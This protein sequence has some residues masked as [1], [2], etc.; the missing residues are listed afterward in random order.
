MNQAHLVCW[1]WGPSMVCTCICLGLHDPDAVHGV[2]VEDAPRKDSPFPIG[3][4]HS[5][6][7]LR[8]GA[9]HHAVHCPTEH[10]GAAAPSE[11]A[12]LAALEVHPRHTCPNA[13]TRKTQRTRG[14]EGG[15]RAGAQ[16]RPWHSA[17]RDRG[18]STP[19]GDPSEP[20]AAPKQDPGKP[21]ARG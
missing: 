4:G 3:K 2:G 16:P 11:E 1:E 12:G 8:R 14:G 20:L 18:L 6:P 17:P 13:E 9:P 10:K 5:S 21:Q 15:M 19:A 7:G